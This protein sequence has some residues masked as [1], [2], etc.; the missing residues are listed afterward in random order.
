M[1]QNK[2]LIDIKL[3]SNVLR[4]KGYEEKLIIIVTKYNYTTNADKEEQIYFMHII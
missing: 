3:L 2:I 1:L 4:N